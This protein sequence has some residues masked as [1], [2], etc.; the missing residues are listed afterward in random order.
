[1]KELND[2]TEGNKPVNEIKEIKVKGN[3]GN[4]ILIEVGSGIY[5]FETA[6]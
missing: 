1:V 2:I 6:Y 5:N 3:S 4:R